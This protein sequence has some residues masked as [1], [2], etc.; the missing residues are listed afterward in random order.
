MSAA[1]ISPLLDSALSGTGAARAYLFPV[2]ARQNT[3]AMVIACGNVIPAPIELLCEA[4]GMKLETFEAFT[5][6]PATQ[7]GPLVQIGETPASEPVAAQTESA[8]PAWSKLTLE[9]QA[10]HL[11]AQRTAR[12]RVAQIRISEPDALRAGAREGNI[13]RAVQRSI[14]NARGEFRDAFMSKSPTMV[15]YL[16]LEIMRSLAHD[17]GRLMG[18]DYPGPIV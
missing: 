2:T 6:V 15:D 17:D 13:Y 14:D 18:E 8:P 16:H 1:E 5:P 9:Q 4:A 12:V 3:V 7:A 11:R 10:L